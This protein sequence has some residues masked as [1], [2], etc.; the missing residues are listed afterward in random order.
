MSNRTGAFALSLAMFA[1]CATTPD[2]PPAPETRKAEVFRIE[3][4]DQSFTE[5]TAVTHLELPAGTVPTGAHWEILSGDPL[6]P[7]ASGQGA[8]PK[9]AVGADGVVQVAGTSTYTDDGSLADLMAEGGS[10]GIVMRGYVEADG[11]HWEFSRAGR[12]RVPRVP[13]ISISRVEAGAVPSEGRIGLVFFI[14]I[15]NQNAFDLELEKI[16]YDLKVA[17]QAI[18]QGIAG[19]KRR[20][21]RATAVEVDLPISLDELNFPNVKQHLRGDSRLDYF[22]DGEVTLGVGRIPFELKGPIQVRSSGH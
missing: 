13:E 6:T 3:I 16:D 20:V 2:G 12:V 22:L 4:R 7:I 15:D 19:T 11:V 1:G 9:E 21:P 10:M 8:L 14:R 17:N 18:D 5:F